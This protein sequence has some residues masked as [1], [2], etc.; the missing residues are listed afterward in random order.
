M[1]HMTSFG[2]WTLWR[3]H[4]PH[5]VFFLT[6]EKCLGFSRVFQCFPSSNSDPGRS[7][8]GSRWECTKIG[9]LKYQQKYRN[10]YPHLQYVLRWSFYRMSKK[11]KNMVVK[12]ESSSCSS[13]KKVI[14]TFTIRC[15]RG[16]TM[17]NMSMHQQ[18]GGEKGYLW[19]FVETCCSTYRSA[20]LHKTFQGLQS[21]R[22][23][24]CKKKFRLDD[25]GCRI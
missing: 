1:N 19:F 5:I 8:W 15:Q 18:T 17:G 22:S 14:A 16:A 11:P 23:N 12:W 24:E 25:V 3:P 20:N 4:R 13:R 6:H 21:L 9:I 7:N 2:E 10:E